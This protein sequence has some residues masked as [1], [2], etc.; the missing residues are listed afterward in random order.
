V[1]D[2]GHCLLGPVAIQ[3]AQPGMTLEIQI[4]EVRVGKWGWIAAGF[5][6]KTNE[7]L[8]VADQFVYQLWDLDADANRGRNNMGL[9]IELNP[10][11]GVMGMPSNEDGILSTAPPRETGG[12]L[13]C[14]ELRPGTSLF[15]PIAVPGGLFSVGD[16]HAAQGDGE[17][18]GTAIEC[19]MKRVSLTFRLHPSLSLKTP[20]IRT[21]EAW[22]C[23]GVDED[24]HEATLKALND[25]L[26]LMIEQYGFSRSDALALAS[27]VVD[28]RVTQIANGVLGVHTVLPHNALTLPQSG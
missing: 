8:G 22:M 12:N 1:L 23:L 13:D 7:R 21:P 16:G 17:V 18:C 14:K 10:F 3:G 25:M 28:T 2:A 24:L 27:L 11:M 4:N 15:L 5:P 20:R 9:E 26:D 19:P 6:S